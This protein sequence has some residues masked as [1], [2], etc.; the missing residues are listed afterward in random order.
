MIKSARTSSEHEELSSNA[1]HPRKKLG[2]ATS[3][4]NRSTEKG[5]GSRDRQILGAG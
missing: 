4:R 5:V 2:I 1:K 3:A